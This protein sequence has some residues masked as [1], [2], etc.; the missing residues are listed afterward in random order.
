MLIYKITNN[1]N[2]KAYIGQTIKKAEERWKEHQRHSAGTHLN[3]QN[4]V[5]Y[6]AMRKYGIQNFSFE[7]LQDNIEDYDQ[8]DKAEMYWIDFYQTFLH[9]YNETSGGQKFHSRLPNKEIIEDYYR[10]KSARKTAKNFNLDHS[11]V[12]DILNH[13]NI[14]RFSKRESLG[15]KISI[16]KENFYKEFNSVVECA[17]WFVKQDFCMTKKIESARTS[18]KLCRKNNK[19]YYGFEIKNIKE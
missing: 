7:V 17:E 10:T 12:D 16:S 1:I 11:T 15:Q 9:G 3:D 5:L 2:N 13:N 4:K 19:K 18:L 14:P 8:L 6:K